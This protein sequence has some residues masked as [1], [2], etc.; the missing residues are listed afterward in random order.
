MPGM[1]PGSLGEPVVDLEGL[2]LS[3]GAI[4]VDA[5]YSSFKLYR[6]PRSG[7]DGRAV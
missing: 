3:G 7:K 1:V 6:F 2:Q 4:R 5:S